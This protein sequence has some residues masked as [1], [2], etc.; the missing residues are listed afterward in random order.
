MPYTV[1]STEKTARSSAEYETKALLYLMNFRSDSNDINFFVFNFFNDVTGMDNFAKNLWDVQSKAKKNNSPSE[2]G[3]ALVTLFKNYNSDFNFAYYI[4]F[5]GGVSA[6][7]RIDSSKNIFDI[8]N[9]KNSAYTKIIQSLQDEAKAKKY[10]KDEDITD[11]NLKNFLNTVLF[12]I[13]DKTPS[14]YIQGM[15]KN[16]VS[17]IPGKDFLTAIF[18]EIRDIQSGKKNISN[19]EGEVIETPDQALDYCRHLTSSEIKMLVLQRII[20]RNPLE[21]GIP[22]YFIPIYNS[23]PE[24]KRSELIDSCQQKLCMALFDKNASEVFWD[25]FEAIY[26]LIVKNPQWDIQTIYNNLETNILSK[27]LHFD[28][29]SLKYFIAI[30]K[31][32]VQG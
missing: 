24:E 29:V 14:D 7:L 30:I 31:E 2:I 28:S 13:D 8:K 5:V 32:G 21:K 22:K 25:G 18:N 11:I 23:A 3:K 12:V 17:I 20:N 16:H 6:S 4:L 15:I 10:V 9:I 27:L 26:L 1:K 19:V